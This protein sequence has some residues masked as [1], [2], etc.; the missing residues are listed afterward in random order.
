MLQISLAAPEVLTKRTYCGKS[1]DAW[2]CGVMLYAMLIAS[3]PFERLCDQNSPSAIK[4]VCHGP[5]NLTNCA[6]SFQS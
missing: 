3:Y 4:E 2:S 6:E 5:Q 1:A